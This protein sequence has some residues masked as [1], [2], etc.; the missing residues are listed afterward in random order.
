MNANE[1]RIGNFLT[2]IKSG[3]YIQFKS[4][5]GLH[6][7]YMNPEVYAP[8]PLT[9]EILLKC[10]F[11]DEMLEWSIIRDVNEISFAGEFDG[12]NF[13]FTAGEGIPLSRK[14]KYLHEL[15]NLYFALTGKELTVNI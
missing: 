2:H 11:E 6:N 10:E 14:I 3:K 7:V 4:F 5:E 15:Q 12:E 9:E 1:L 13:E 8:I